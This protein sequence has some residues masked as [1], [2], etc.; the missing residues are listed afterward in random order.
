MS[1]VARSRAASAGAMKTIADFRRQERFFTVA[2]TT[3][4]PLHALDCDEATARKLI[5]AANSGAKS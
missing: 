2:L 4:R 1:R 5:E 3:E